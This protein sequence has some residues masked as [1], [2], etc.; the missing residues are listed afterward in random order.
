MPASPAKSEPSIQPEAEYSDLGISTEVG[1]GG[2]ARL[3]GS[4]MHA[5]FVCQRAEVFP[6]VSLGEKL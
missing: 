4:H 5:H 1:G 3:G 2:W 6:N